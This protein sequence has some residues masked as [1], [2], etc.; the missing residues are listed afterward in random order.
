MKVTYKGR[1]HRTDATGDYD[2]DTGKIIVKKGSIVSESIAS[3][4]GASSVIRMR[5]D[6]ID[7]DGCLKEDTL[8]ST[9]SAAAAFVTGYSANGLLTWHVEKH[10]TLSD[11]LKNKRGE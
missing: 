11:F 9:P 5:Q 4:P 3:F 1:K 8:F 2:I 10:K 6:R 7:A